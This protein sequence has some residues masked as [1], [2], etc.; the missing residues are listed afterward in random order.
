MK[1]L[2]FM[3]QLIFLLLFSQKVSCD[4]GISGMDVTSIGDNSVTKESDYTN[5]FNNNNIAFFAANNKFST[6]INKDERVY[7]DSYTLSSYNYY[8]KFYI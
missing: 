2:L 8:Y 6:F 3:T 4:K 5:W 7:P 1:T